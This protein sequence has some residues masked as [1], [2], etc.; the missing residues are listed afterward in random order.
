MLP[1]SSCIYNTQVFLSVKRYF[2]MSRLS[3]LEALLQSPP[4]FTSSILI[5]VSSAL[6]HISFCLPLHFISLTD[7]LV[8]SCNFLVYSVFSSSQ[9]ITTCPNHLSCMSLTYLNDMF[10][11]CIFP[12]HFSF[13]SINE[14]PSTG[15]TSI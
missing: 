12:Y 1:N 11:T 14:S 6:L 8:S 2:Q 9:L 10:H 13:Q 4:L 3:F 5:L 7:S 15:R